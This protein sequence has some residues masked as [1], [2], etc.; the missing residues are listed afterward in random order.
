MKI[1][2]IKPYAYAHNGTRVEYFEAGQIVEACEDLA[3]N[4]ILDKAATSQD[5]PVIT[6]EIPA[7]KPKK[8]A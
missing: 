8:K 4:A 6:E 7:P 3:Q 2:F 1:K 5:A